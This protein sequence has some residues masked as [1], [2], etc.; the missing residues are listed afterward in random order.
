MKEYI[1]RSEMQEKLMKT[2][3]VV[4]QE[5]MKIQPEWV[6]EPWNRC[7]ILASKYVDAGALIA[8]LSVDPNENPGCPEPEYLPELIELLRQAP[9]EDV[10][11]PV[12][13]RE[14][15]HW[16]Q[17]LWEGD[18]SRRLD[19]GKCK[20]WGYVKNGNWYC[21]DARRKDG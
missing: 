9:A 16:D 5:L 3:T 12:R 7:G 13:C 17:Q 20:M 19:R 6:D 21:G 4:W 8:N 15:R 2:L 10:V 1:L 18:D 11:R 14:C